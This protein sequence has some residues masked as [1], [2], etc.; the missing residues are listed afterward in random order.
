MHNSEL[1]RIDNWEIYLNRSWNGS[2]LKL[3][4]VTISTFSF[5]IYA[6]LIREASGYMH[7]EQMIDVS[8][9]KQPKQPTVRQ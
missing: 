7:T 6:M 1:A 4:L 8:E 2:K 5:P 9:W 3:I